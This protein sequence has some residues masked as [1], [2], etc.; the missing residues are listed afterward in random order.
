[1][2]SLRK[3]DRG[4]WYSNHKEVFSS[5]KKLRESSNRKHRH[6]RDGSS[7]TRVRSKERKDNIPEELDALVEIIEEDNIC[8]FP[9][10]L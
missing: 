9:I 6:Q 8:K 7:L 2:R 4:L 10:C 3:I 1:M 5:A